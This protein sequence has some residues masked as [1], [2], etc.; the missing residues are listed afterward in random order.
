MNISPKQ[1]TYI[2]VVSLLLIFATQAYLVFDYFQTTRAALIR[3]SDAIVDDVFQ[4]DLGYRHKIYDHITHQDTITVLPAPTKQNTTRFDAKKINDSSGNLLNMVDLTI[5]TYISKIVPMDM[6]KTDSITGAI[7]QKRNI[8]SAYAIKIINPK[9]GDVLAQSKKGLKSSIFLIP[10]KT[11]RIDLENQK[12]LQLILINPFGII[13]KRMGLML[14]SSLALSIICLLG[15]RLLIRILAR[16][17]QL[18]AFK[19][20]FLGTIAHELKRP[21]ASLTFNLD[22]LAMP[23]A[24]PQQHDMLVSK[25]INATSELNDTITMIV[26]LAKEEEG[27]LTLSRERVNLRSML[28][29]LSERFE[30]AAVKKVDIKT[31][32][33]TDLLTVMGDRRLLTQC[34]A[35]LIDNA[36]KYSNAEVQITI[37]VRKAGHYTAVAIKDNGFGIPAGKL[38]DIF[39]KYNRAHAENKKINGYGIG[40]NYVK[41]I[42]EKHG[43][44]VEVTSREGTGSEFSVLLPD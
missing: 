4:K 5:N 18:V 8:H 14:L 32:Y 9:T 33:E 42:V 2:A 43:G 39:D 3:E 13:I 16:Q 41:T 28:E 35:N 22:C 40:L 38:P 26:A 30:S 21:V 34:F 20:E 17:K 36:I 10:S 29:E 6:Q 19:N 12:A 27:L 7:L 37:S 15:F 31:G 44:K 24:D 1:I 25:S 11:L 23:I